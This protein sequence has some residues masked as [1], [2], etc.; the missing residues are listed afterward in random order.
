MYAIRE[1]WKQHR[2]VVRQ[3]KLDL[4]EVLVKCVSSTAFRMQS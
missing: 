4:K 1:R 2:K 3:R